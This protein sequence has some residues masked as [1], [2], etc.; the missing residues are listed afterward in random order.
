MRSIVLKSLL[1]TAAWAPVVCLHPARAEVRLP[2]LISDNMVLQQDT[3]ANVWGWADPG[4]LVTVRFAGRSAAT[5]ADSE[6]AWSVQFDALPAGA[7]GD[8]TI[9]GTN[10]RIIKNVLVGEVWLCAGQSPMGVPVRAIHQGAGELGQADIPRLR[11]FTVDKAASHFP[12]LRCEGSWQICT[13]Q[14]ARD[15]SA[16]GYFFGRELMKQLDSPVGLIVAT[17]GD[18]PAE[19]WTPETALR[20]DPRLAT[21]IDGGSVQKPQAKPLEPTPAAPVRPAKDLGPTQT[22]PASLFNG[23]IA[24]LTPYT[25][26]GALWH[27]GEAD[28]RQ[29]HRHR[30][31]FP[32]LIVSWRQA[33]GREF[34]FLFLQLGGTGPEPQHPHAPPEESQ[35][36]ELRE[37]QRL[38]LDLRH[39]AMAVSVDLAEGIPPKNRRE[40]GRRLALAA[41]AT[42]YY[43]ETPYSGPMLSSSQEELGKIR[44]SFRNARNLRPADG[45]KLKGFAIAGEDG[46]FVWADAQIEGDHVMVSHPRIPKP[47][48]VRYGWADNPDCNLINGDGLP[49]SPFR[50]DWLVGLGSGSGAVP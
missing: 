23:M 29:A 45:G 50:S 20:A 14:N 41:A 15:F 1:L 10:T 46:R 12:S 21:V 36:A 42:V 34:P 13:P 32:A 6:G 3:R 11:V 39:T 5:A 4:E 37:A 9:S 31:L 40:I 24:P 8:L 48:A 43:R 17:D 44:L 27:P 33:W 47:T 16:T 25:I 22:G 19:N 18:A 35:R 30:R 49:A 7:T 38:A 28:I 2:A 26:Q